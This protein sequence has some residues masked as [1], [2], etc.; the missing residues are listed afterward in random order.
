[1]KNF[2]KKINFFR[3]LCRNCFY[4]GELIKKVIYRMVGVTLCVV[5]LLADELDLQFMYLY[6]CGHIGLD[7]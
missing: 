2:L 1:M 3:F 4:F 5:G 7:E 6:R